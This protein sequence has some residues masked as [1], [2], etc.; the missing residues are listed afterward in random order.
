MTATET[1]VRNDE[2][3]KLPACCTP[4]TRETGTRMRDLTPAQQRAV[5]YAQQQILRARAA[6]KAKDERDAAKNR[7]WGLEE[8]GDSTVSKGAATA[9]KERRGDRSVSL[10]EAIG[11][12]LRDLR[13]K[14]RKTLREVSAKA[15]VSL[16]YLSEVE[17]GQKEASSE[18]LS[19]IAE[20]LGVSV[21]QMLRMVADYLESS[22]D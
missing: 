8:S 10:R 1:I 9:A 15:G 7:M 4:V 3:V 13:T 2:T 16:G 18:L 11:H 19:S 12:V 5:M 20:S 17:R 14:D 6:K 21:S 22:E